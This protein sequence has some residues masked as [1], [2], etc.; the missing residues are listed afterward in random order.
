M[1]RYRARWVLPIVS[2]PIEQAWVDVAD[3]RIVAVGPSGQE[4]GSIGDERNLGNV[5]ILPGLTN[6]HTHLELSS[7]R[8]LVPPSSSMPAWV[9]TLFDARRVAEITT[10]AIESAVA[11]LERDG[12]AVVGDIGNTRASLPALTASRLH[13]VHFRELLGFNVV[14]ADRPVRTAVGEMEHRDGAGRVREALAAHAPYSTSPMLFRAIDEASRAHPVSVRS[15]HLAESFDEVE[16]LY[17]GEGAWR[18]MLEELDLWLEG[19][20]PPGCRPVAFLERL[21]WLGPT[22]LVAHGVQ[23]DDDELAAL[24]RAGCTLVTCPRSNQWVGVGTPPV[25]RF[26]ASGVRVAVGTDSLASAPDLN[27]FAELAELRRLAP[28]VPAATLL[29]WATVNG[30]RALGFSDIGAVTPGSKAALIAVALP[31]HRTD[32]EECLLQGVAP[33]R[34]QRI[35]AL[36]S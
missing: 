25:S 23:L 29:A 16:F 33:E 15:V 22:T 26:A 31:H 10:L 1:I 17:T 28:E 8:G 4:Q 6:A 13:A 34:V 36:P 7:L 24:A 18:T 21:G 9:R 30:A 11:D 32:V 5:A 20:R 35:D 14:N 27:V 2:P 19:W 12:T 3:G